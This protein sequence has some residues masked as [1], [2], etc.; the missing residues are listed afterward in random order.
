MTF[1][2]NHQAGFGGGRR[3]GEKRGASKGVFLVLALSFCLAGCGNGRERQEDTEME[4]ITVVN[5]AVPVYKFTIPPE[6]SLGN[7]SKLSAKFLVDSANY[8]KQARARAY[9]AF[10]SGF[11][12]D[13][14]DIFFLDFG[15][16]DRDRNGP[17]LLSNVV[18]SNRNISAVSDNAGAN[19]WF[20]LEFPLEGKRHQR[21]EAGNF[22]GAGA[23]GDFYFA[24]GLG[25][26]SASLGF[27]YYVKDVAL[28]GENGG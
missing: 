8:R 23:N 9:G 24:L 6:D 26:G 13:A 16:G 7:Y 20:T 10:P 4:K 1:C 14:G 5:G 27:T 25:T 12:Y 17:Y 18:E 22:P 3:G 15:E 19:T 11:F 28:L 21:Y 2:F